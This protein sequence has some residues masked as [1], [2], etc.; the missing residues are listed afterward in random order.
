LIFIFGALPL[1]V[2]EN[3]A[4]LSSAGK[5]TTSL[6]KQRA[7]WLFEEVAYGVIQGEI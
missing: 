4:H 2:V 1:T 6:P 5:T 7:M 3:F